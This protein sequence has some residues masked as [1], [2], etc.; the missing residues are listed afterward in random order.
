MRS[1][2]IARVYALILTLFLL[3]IV[4]FALLLMIPGDVVQMIIGAEAE[5]VSPNL[6]PSCATSLVSIC[7]GT[8]ILALGKTSTT[9]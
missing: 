1:Y 4:V 9:R 5:H 6:S 8:S 7:P 2:L 3:T